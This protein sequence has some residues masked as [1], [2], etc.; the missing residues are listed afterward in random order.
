M[1][2]HLLADG[3]QTII[4]ENVHYPYTNVIITASYYLSLTTMGS[5]DKHIFLMD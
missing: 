4:Q 1:V 3:M 2:M 5:F